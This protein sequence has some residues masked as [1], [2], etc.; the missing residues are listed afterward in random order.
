MQ[1]V[2]GFFLIITTIL[3]FL[4]GNIPCF[5]E[6]SANPLVIEHFPTQ[7]GNSWEYRR[8]FQVVVYDTVNNDT[9]EY[10]LIDSLHEEFE[11]IDTLAGWECY[12]L[13]RILFE[14]GD[15]FPETWWYAHPD[16]ALLWI[17]YLY[18]NESRNSTELKNNN[19]KFWIGE[20]SFDSP[21]ALAQYLYCIKYTKFLP[22]NLDTAYWLP[23]KKLFIF[24]LDVGK[25]WVAMTDPWLE[26][27]EI[28]AEDSVTVPAGTFFTL[29][30]EIT[31]E[32]MGEVD[33]WYKWIT[34][35]GI[36]KD[37]MYTR[38]IAT[39]TLG[40]IIGYYDADDIYE[41]LDFQIGI[42]ETTH[43]QSSIIRGLQNYP[44]P[45]FSETIIR[46]S[47]LRETDLTLRVYDIS[48]RLVKTLINRKQ[49]SDYYTIK[50]DG[51]D[52]KDNEVRPGIYFLKA[53]GCKPVKVV[54]LRR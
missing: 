5:A 49:L 48:G 52:A 42:E 30:M 29:R 14:Q 43:Q 3:F 9:I 27:R 19:I 40:N 18:S 20:K 38:G 37:T 44:N 32:W 34:E 21:Q 17:A 1:Y 25:Y 13:H 24:P 10:L 8:T 2:K 50:W 26:E 54:K 39:D 46:Y 28:I 31:S 11:D 4:S 6:S 7:V 22:L 12:R 47:V 45:F 35:E 23:P 16:T 51:K 36:I 41:L 15:T 33:L 53:T